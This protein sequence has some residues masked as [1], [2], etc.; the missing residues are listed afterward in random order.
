MS[1]HDGLGRNDPRV[2]QSRQETRSS[3]HFGLRDREISRS[4]PTQPLPAPLSAIILKAVGR[5]GTHT[6]V[7]RIGGYRMKL[8]HNRE[9]GFGINR[10]EH[11]ECT[12]GYARACGA[13]ISR[14]LN[15]RPF[16]A[17]HR[18]LK[19]WECLNS[20]IP[21]G[22]WYYFPISIPPPP[23]NVQIRALGNRCIC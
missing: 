5:A 19:S 11:R 2:N 1:A 8:E 12:A 7:V 15:S 14:T 17:A 9:T 18:S 4:E 22:G 13:R 3:K 10:C 16:F 20:E 21:R 23:P 6:A